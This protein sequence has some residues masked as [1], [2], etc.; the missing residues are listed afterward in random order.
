MLHFTRAEFVQKRAPIFVLLEIFGDVSGN[1]N[2]P[3]VAA[4][5]YPLGNVN[6][7]AGDV[8]LLI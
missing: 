3:G 7:G 2:V 4:I 1:E 6:T 8:G 5:H